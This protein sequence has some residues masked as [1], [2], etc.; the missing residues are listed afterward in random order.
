M[1]L[2]DILTDGMFAAVGSKGFGVISA[3]PLRA[4]PFL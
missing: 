3:P 1:I 2:L 4:F